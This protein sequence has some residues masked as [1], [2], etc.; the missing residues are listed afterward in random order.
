MRAI[1]QVAAFL[2][3][4][5]DELIDPDAAVRE[6][7]TMAQLLDQLSEG[8]KRQFVA[9]VHAEVEAGGPAAYREFLRSLPKTL[10]GIRA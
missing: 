1:V 6:L 4:S 10:L 9:F 2:E 3:L 7:E 8:E 5:P